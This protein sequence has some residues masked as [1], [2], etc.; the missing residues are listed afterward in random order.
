MLT[1]GNVTRAVGALGDKHRLDAAA[2]LDGSGQ[3]G[4]ALLLLG[5]IEKVPA[6]QLNL[7][8]GYLTNAG[9]DGE[10]AVGK[11]RRGADVDVSRSAA[12]LEAVESFDAGKLR[13]ASVQHPALPHLLR[14]HLQAVAVVELGRR[15]P[16][17]G[18]HGRKEVRLQRGVGLV[19]VGREPAGAVQLVQDRGLDGLAALLPDLGV[20]GLLQH[21]VGFLLQE[22]LGEL[23]LDA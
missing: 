19:D 18:G 1:L 11:R 16:G 10:R 23:C 17:A 15:Q 20:G 7:G 2:F 22:L 6:L 9:L 13:H 4:D 12:Q 5:G 8:Q 3:V 21:A 14:S